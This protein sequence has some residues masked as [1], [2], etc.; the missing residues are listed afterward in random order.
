MPRTGRPPLKDKLSET[1]KV[2]V[3]P[4]DAEAF[5]AACDAARVQAPDVLRELI[6]AWAQFVAANPRATLHFKLSATGGK[7]QGKHSAH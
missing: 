2:L 4:D 1:I 3:Y 6:H 5:R 7:S